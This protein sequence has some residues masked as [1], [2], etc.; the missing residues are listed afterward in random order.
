[1]LT[2]LLGLILL[3]LREL[4]AKKIVMGLFLISTLVLLL[5]A[6]ALNLDV[7]EGSLAGIQVFGQEAV[8]PGEMEVPEDGEDVEA[9][10]D[11]MTLDRVVLMIESAVAGATYWIGILLALF[12][13]APLFTRLLQPGHIDLL[14]SKPMSRL[15]LISG[16]TLGVW[17]TMLILAVY[18]LGGLWLIMSIK[19]GVWNFSFLLSILVVV[20]MFAVMYAPIMFM[21]VWTQS[22]ALALITTYGLIFVS[23]FLAGGETLAT[24][25]GTVS[26]P[27]FW[28]LYHTL[29][30]FTEVTMVISALAQAEPVASWYPLLS[31]LFFAAV[32]YAAS[33]V[34]FARRDF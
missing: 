3:T 22:T 9:M 5:A 15:Q 4:W 32:L 27:I 11:M 8:S 26:E 14:L 31:S 30:N 29:P 23:M 24:Q 1:M 25:L 20:G 12:A 2:S 6:F 10:Q 28:G 16:H 34:W 18:L 7:V 13:V 19:T 33:V 17:I 21:G